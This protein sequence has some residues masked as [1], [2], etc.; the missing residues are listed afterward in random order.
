MS[1]L[2]VLCNS[3]ATSGRLCTRAAPPS[4]QQ[5]TM[6]T[7]RGGASSL[8]LLLLP[9]KP[10]RLGCCSCTTSAPAHASRTQQDPWLHKR[11]SSMVLYVYCSKCSSYCTTWSQ[12]NCCTRA[13]APEK[14]AV[15]NKL[16]LLT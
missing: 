11:S 8:L 5:K 1:L 13:E 10:C 16:A 14:I 3:R 15:F 4:T 7:A 2:S 12:S 9:L 6:V